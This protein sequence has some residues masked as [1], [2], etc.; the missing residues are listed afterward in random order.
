MPHTTL[1]TSMADDITATATLKSHL[2]AISL[3]YGVYAPAF[4]AAG[5]KRAEELQCCREA[6]VLTVPKGA[7]CCILA[8]AADMEF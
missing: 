5:Y 1:Q 4:F 2:N 8:R 6:D 3:A 7:L